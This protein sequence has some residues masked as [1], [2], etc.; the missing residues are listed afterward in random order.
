MSHFLATA[1]V[2]YAYFIAHVAPIL[3]AST[4]P[5]LLVALTP[6]PKAGKF[7]KAL[8][9]IG[10]MLSFLTHKDAPGTLKAP[11]TA[12]LDHGAPS[13]PR[14]AGLTAI[15]L[16]FLMVLPGCAW[17]KAHP[18]IMGALNCGAA[19]IMN[20]LPTVL[21]D[22][23][24]ALSGQSPDW[25]KLAELERSHS[26]DLIA[27]AASKLIQAI[28]GASVDPRVAHN[29]RAYLDNRGFVTRF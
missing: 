29:A 28:P 7:L 9:V 6:Y 21:S 23:A 18:V 2:W 25:G 12:K 11:L 27:C 15:A 17:L 24:G 3:L 4:I 26:P 22:V 14:G 20:L 8:S 5:S 13:K 10:Q 1:A 16:A 19:E